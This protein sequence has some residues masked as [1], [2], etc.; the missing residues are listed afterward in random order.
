MCNGLDWREDVSCSICCGEVK[1]GKG[2]LSKTKGDT[3]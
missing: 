2:L 1:L 3:M